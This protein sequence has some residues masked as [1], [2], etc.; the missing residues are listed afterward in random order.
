MNVLFLSSHTF[1]TKEIENALRKRTDLTVLTIDVPQYPQTPYIETL[2]DQISYFL[3]ALVISVNDGGFDY[4]GIFQNILISKGCHLA[5][6]YHDYPFYEE[7]FHGRIMVPQKKCL[8]FVSEESFVQESR[9][10]GFNSF[11]LPLATDPFYFYPDDN[12]RYTKDISFVGNSSSFFIDSVI[13]E[14][15]GQEIEKII[16]VLGMIKKQY[17]GNPMSNI[18]DLLILKESL[19]ENKTNLA[20]NELLFILEWLCGYFYR[21]DFIVNIS[22][23]YQKKFNCFGDADWKHFIDPLQVSTEACYYTT[24]HEIY[25]SSK[26]NLNIN[27]IQIRTSFTQRIFD[28]SACGGFILTDK[29]KLNNTFFCTRGMQKELVEF[30]SFE[31][32]TSLIDFY[33]SH[34]EERLEITERAKKKV[35]KDHTYDN[36]IET[37]LEVCKKHWKI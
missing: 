11:F 2:I 25:K 35:L 27:R 28:C 22:Q 18:R 26:I 14:K 17:Y 13:T 29:R 12:I 9:D 21:R 15:R 1:L 10:R 16:S 36:R 31:E 34:E 23:K 8:F 20:R 30:S 4:K 37:M 6:W 5:N 19:W 33:L 3:P 32:C 7:I 24:L